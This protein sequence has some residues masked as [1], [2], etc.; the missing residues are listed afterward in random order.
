MSFAD[1]APFHNLN[2][3]RVQ[4]GG[5]LNGKMYQKPFDALL[6]VPQKE[7]RKLLFSNRT[8]GRMALIFSNTIIPRETSGTQH[9]FLLFSTM[10]VTLHPFFRAMKMA[11]LKLPALRH[12][13]TAPVASRSK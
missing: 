10:Y 4:F 12:S 1:G 11:R 2:A 9:F 3:S 7:N 6:S 5:N 13:S 8:L